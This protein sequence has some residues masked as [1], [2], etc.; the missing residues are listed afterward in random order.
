MA[1]KA[2]AAGVLPISAAAT[3]KDKPANSHAK[4]SPRTPAPKLRLIVR[5]LAPGLTESEF[6]DAL[7]AE[8]KVGAGKIDW[9]AFKEG[10][11]SKEYDSP[12][13]LRVCI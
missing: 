9:A 7:G 1:A 10:K 2:R 4:S 13:F 8:W 12:T 6:W 11:I 5:R 3:K